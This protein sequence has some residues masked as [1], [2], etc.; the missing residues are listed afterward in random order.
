M[1]NLKRFYA[2]AIALVMLVGMLVPATVFA[3]ESNYAA[4]AKVLYDLGL[5][6]GVDATKF[7]PDL[8][9]TLNRETATVMVLRMFGLEA[10]A[11]SMTDKDA[12]D[13]LMA[14]GMT[15]ASAISAWALK[16][17]AYAV[18]NDIIKGFPDKTFQPKG[19]L[20]GKQYCTI[21][22]RLLGYEGDFSFE[23]AG[24]KFATVA[25]LDATD[26]AAFD[27]SGS[28]KKNILVGIS[29]KALDSMPK[30][31]TVTQAQKLLD[32]G[33]VTEAALKAAGIAYTAKVVVTPTPATSTSPTTSA[34]PTVVTDVFGA[35]NV[36]FTAEA[37][38]SVA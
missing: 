4:D 36:T 17:V 35:V 23:D 5:Y 27:V 7:A 26:A 30:D 29:R 25:N 10:D 24:K 31:E 2:V 37:A 20:T 28:V 14:A 32:E 18:E 16:S 38:K 12:T 21:V 1:R 3:A 13:A 6:K 11:L 8:D 22:L 19:L 15:D 9:S 33:V 34:T